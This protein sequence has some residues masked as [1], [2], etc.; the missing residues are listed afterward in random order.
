MNN[1]RRNG[2]IV[3]AL[4]A[5]SVAGYLSWPREPVFEGRT[6]SDW[7]EEVIASHHERP[8]AEA[9]EAVSAVRSIGPSAVPHLLRWL[10]SAPIASPLRDKVQEL[11]GDDLVGVNVVAHDIDGTGKNRL[12]NGRNVPRTREV[13]NQN[14]SWR[15]ADVH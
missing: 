8:S 2:L 6:L 14:S 13:F 4:I 10:R 7:L 1:G 5:A 11:R 3:L 12:H 15:P 9:G